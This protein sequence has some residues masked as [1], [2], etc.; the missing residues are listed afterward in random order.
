MR[1][2]LKLFT[3]LP[4][5]EFMQTA[6]ITEIKKALNQSTQSELVNMC[7]HLSKFKK[8]T[9][10]LITY[11]LFEASDEHSYIRGVKK[12]IDELFEDL[13]TSNFYYIKK[14]VRKTLRRTKIY[15]RYSKKRETELELILHFCLKLAQLKPSIERNN[16]LF[17]IFDRELIRMEKL[18]IKLHEDLQYDYNNEI[19]NLRSLIH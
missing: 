5:F 1:V 2:K 19:K 13:N 3:H 7:I 8:E 9:K 11:L 12:E 18:V 16:I 17:N 6:T 14:G 4:I 10:E 15:I